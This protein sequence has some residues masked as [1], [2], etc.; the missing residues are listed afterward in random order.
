[1]TRR[2][3]AVLALGLAVYV[4]AWVFGSL[5]LFPVA[6][7][8]VLAVGLAV[9]WVRLASR[10]PHVS[11]HGASRDVIEGDDVRIELEVRVTA[12]VPPPTLVAHESPGR[13]G[14]RRVE[15][16]RVARRRF[17]AVYELDR[18]PRGRYAFDAVRLTI[19]DPF[20]LA[21]TELVQG[22]PQ[23]LVVYPRLVQLD[24]L[25]SE[26]GAHAQD[27]RRLLLRRPTGFELHSVREY[28]QGESLRKVH[29]RSTARRGRLMV[30]ELEDAPRDEVAVLLDGDARTVDGESFEVAVRAAG[31]ILAAHHRQHRRCALVV[32]ST[33][34]ETQEIA[35]AAHWRRTLEI[36]AGAEPT[37]RTPVFALLD[38]NG[39]IASRSLELVVV[40]ARVDVPLADRLV[41]RA[42]SRRGVSVVY[43]ET[44]AAPEPQLLRLQAVGIPVAIVRP[45]GDLAAALSATPVATAAHA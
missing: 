23:A 45:G 22:E 35:T 7:G 25:F 39:G 1:M 12:T 14:E 30:K 9:A 41:Q 32:N 31:S 16:R 15:L 28:E 24:R 4:A 44:S 3:R 17:A 43:V 8:L 20:S 18:V 42:L 10:L 13:L 27:G 2:G 21:R 36:L 40:T 19:E 29:W 6:T 11:R 38:A 33:A 37:S 34:L 26:G 5:A